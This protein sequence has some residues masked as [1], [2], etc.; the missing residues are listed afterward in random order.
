MRRICGPCI[1][2]IVLGIVLLFAA[3]EA[4]AA[5][6]LQNVHPTDVTLSGFSV[7]WQASQPAVPGITVFSDAAGADDA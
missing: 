5:V 7:I 6:T 1:H 2:L 4:G 3:S